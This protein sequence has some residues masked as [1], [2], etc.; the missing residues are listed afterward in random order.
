MGVCSCSPHIRKLCW[1]QGFSLVG[2][3]LWR[4]SRTKMRFG[5]KLLDASSFQSSSL[6]LDPFRKEIT[7]QNRTFPGRL[8]LICRESPKVMGTSCTPEN[9]LL[10][11]V[12]ATWSQ[13]YLS[14]PRCRPFLP[15]MGGTSFLGPYIP[16]WDCLLLFVG[17]IPGSFSG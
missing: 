17:H 4:R 6:R 3:Y 13:I 5:M 2:Q 16:I 10:R 9:R 7:S 8:S 1:C 11:P 14:T 12:E 15:L